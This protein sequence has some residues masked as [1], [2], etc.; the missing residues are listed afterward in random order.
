MVTRG[1]AIIIEIRVRVVWGSICKI[2]RIVIQNIKDNPVNWGLANN[3]HQIGDIMVFFVVFLFFV[4]IVIHNIIYI[5]YN[6]YG[7]TIYILYNICG[8]TIYIYI[9]GSQY[10]SLIVF[11]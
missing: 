9:Y 10:V 5:L 2:I 6:I 11:M 8:S 3:L 7:F 1:Y 4:T